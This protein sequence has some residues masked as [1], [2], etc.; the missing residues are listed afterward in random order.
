MSVTEVNPRDDEALSLIN[1][2]GIYVL[3]GFI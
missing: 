2:Y 1:Y 3:K